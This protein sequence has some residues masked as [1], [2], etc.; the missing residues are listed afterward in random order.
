MVVGQPQPEAKDSGVVQLQS[1]PPPFDPSIFV[2]V[3]PGLRLD[4]D[5]LAL[6]QRMATRLNGSAFVP[7]DRLLY[8]AAYADSKTDTINSWAALVDDVEPNGDGC[9]VTIRVQPGIS[10]TIS[11]P[12]TILLGPDDYEQYQVGDDRV[13]Y[14]GFLDPQGSAGRRFGYIGL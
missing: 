13:V 5:A 6:Y 3:D 14:Q 8:Y 12:A 4:A 9:L 2:E 7:K 10:S 11:G 1:I